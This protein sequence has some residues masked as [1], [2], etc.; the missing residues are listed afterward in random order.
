MYVPKQALRTWYECFSVFLNENYLKTW[1]SRHTIVYKDYSNEFIML[2][3]YVNGIIFCA[4]N[5]LFCQEFLSFM[6]TEFEMSMVGEL[7]FFLGF[8]IKQVDNFI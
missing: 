4:T 7:R 1:T 8:Q 6:S 2:Q 5:E 3:I